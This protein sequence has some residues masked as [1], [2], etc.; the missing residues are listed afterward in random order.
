[1]TLWI[2]LLLYDLQSVQADV[3]Q[4]NVCLLGWNLQVSICPILGVQVLL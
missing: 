4:L 2:V 3:Q 1:M